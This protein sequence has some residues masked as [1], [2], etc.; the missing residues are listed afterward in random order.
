[1][2]HC[3]KAARQVDLRKNWLNENGQCASTLDNILISP[4]ADLINQAIEKIKL[5]DAFFTNGHTLNKEVDAD[6]NILK[7]S[8]DAN[9]TINDFS[10]DGGHFY[11][12]FTESTC[13]QIECGN[14]ACYR[15]MYLLVFP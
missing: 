9:V 2:D 11:T 12:A 13:I 7:I 5:P 1:L 15:I 3:E 6:P 4:T 14:C 10:T 8:V